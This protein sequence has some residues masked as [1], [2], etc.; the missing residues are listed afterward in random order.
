[1]PGLLP[2]K[3]GFS[4]RAY[5]QVPI[6]DHLGF[7]FRKE[8]MSTQS[9]DSTQQQ[10]EA[11]PPPQAALGTILP[12]AGLPQTPPTRREIVVGRPSEPMLESFT[13]E[14]ILLQLTKQV[15]ED[16][17]VRDLVMLHNEFFPDEVELSELKA[18][19]DLESVT[20]RI[21]EHMGDTTDA[22]EIVEWWTLVF[23]L[24]RSIRYNKEEGRFYF[25]ESSPEQPDA[26]RID[27]RLAPLTP[28]FVTPTQWLPWPQLPLWTAICRAAVHCRRFFFE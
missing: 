17:D 2:A 23:P 12:E 6:F 13:D 8:T 25:D 18:W 9:I 3:Q 20:D 5:W 21:V 1:M 11:S 19:E 4:S 24:R 10:A 14:E 28:F 7:S 22:E 27:V 26:K 15:E 16:L